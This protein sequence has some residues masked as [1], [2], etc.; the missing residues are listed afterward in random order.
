MSTSLCRMMKYQT[1]F[2][3]A[4]APLALCLAC[5]LLA[6]CSEQPPLENPTAFA[7]SA[8]ENTV[9]LSWE[10][11]EGADFYRLYRREG[12]GKD[13]KY[14][15][16]LD[17]MQYRDA[18]IK[19]D[20]RYSYKV[21]S[22]CGNRESSGAVI[23]DIVLYSS[24]D[25]ALVITAPSISSV[26]RL[27][28]YSAVL[29]FTSENENCVYRISRASEVN[30][31][32]E[33]IGTTSETVY[34][35]YNTD[36][37]AFYYTVTAI[38]NGKA[39]ASLPQRTGYNARGVFRIPAM[40][41]HE[42]VTQ[43]DL[44]SG[45]LF[46]EYAIWEHEFERDLQWVAENG[47][48]TI[49]S[50]QLIDFLEGKGKLPQKPILLTIDDGKYG[51]YKRAYPLLKKYNMVAVLALIGSEIDNATLHPEARATSGAP[52]C[53]WDEI[54]EMQKSGH[55]EMISHTQNLHIFSHDNRTGANTAAGEGPD[56]YLPVAQFDFSKFNQNLKAATGTT[57]ETMAYPYSKRS[58]AS[59]S[60][61]LKSGYKVLFCGD[62]LNV[63]LTQF[64]Y[65]IAEA[66]INSRS[67]L[68]RRVARMTG[69]P[70]AVYME[71]ALSEGN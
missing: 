24:A 10:S 7:A 53:T 65:Y 12:N 31:Q 61:W 16:D 56:T 54:A 62:N 28:R 63:S 26:T 42:F 27:N 14:L 49:T 69:T 66:G 13:F 40:M 47:Y 9:L 44:D 21:T 45:V 68:V 57:T 18:K 30:G 46:D 64:N 70:L 5:L 39:E 34:Y 71:D 58:P 48:T 3:K 19:Q 67:A 37:E 1:E 23:N 2:K 55:F 4:I 43:E 35:D 29:L 15:D 20:V 38:G 36:G 50:R 59:D 60:A 6:A 17:G 33:V 8:E 22:V 32:Y 52:Y 11:G 25:H 51:V 41:Y